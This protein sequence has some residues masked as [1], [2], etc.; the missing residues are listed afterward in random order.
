MPKRARELSAQEVANLSE[1]GR[2]AVGGIVPGLHLRIEGGCKSWVLRKAVHGQRRDLGLGSYPRV[3]LSAARKQA[4]HIHVNGPP[5]TMPAEKVLVAAPPMTAKTT[6]PSADVCEAVRASGYSF[7]WCSQTYIAAQAPGWK[8]GKHAKQWL[9]TLQKYAF[10]VIGTLD[11]ATITNSHVTT[12]LQPIW[13]TKT[14]TATRVRGRM[15]SILDWATHKGYRQGANPARW[16]GNLQHELP[17]PTK[18]KKRKQRHHPALPYTRLGAFMVD[19]SSRDGMS[20]RA[21]EWGILNAS[22]FQ[23]IAGARRREVDLQLKRWTIP[24]QRMKREIEHVVPLSDE[25]IALFN[26]LPPGTPDDLL[27]PAPEGGQLSDSALGAMI[28]GIHESDLAR[29][30]TGYRDPK[31]GRIATQHGFRST[32]RD[33]ASEVGYFD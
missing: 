8:S 27:F 15:E 32:F 13:T 7:E 11:V 20:A 22:R 12:I 10:P 6:T 25:A 5:A 28:D 24:A 1:E 30:G 23:E 4:L 26:S 3:S 31:E 2:H 18:L 21:L 19:L 14:E 33:W 16:E 17:S 29:G 9:A